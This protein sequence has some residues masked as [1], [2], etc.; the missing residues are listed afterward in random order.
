[1]M[2]LRHS[3]RI[4]RAAA[5]GGRVRLAAVPLL[6]LGC[7]AGAQSIQ[8]AQPAAPTQAY[9]DYLIGF[10]LADDGSRVEALRHLA[11]SLR[12]EPANNPAAALVFELLTEQRT[13]SRLVLRGHTGAINAVAFSPDGATLVTASGDHT[14]RLWNAAT[15]EP[16]T[17][18]LEHEDAVLSVA[19]SPDG[20]RLVT[21]C[22]DENARLWDVATGKQIGAA[23]NS[24]GNI[25]AV[26]FSPDGKLVSTGSDEGRARTWDAMTGQPVSPFVIYHEAVYSVAFNP[27]G[28]RLLTGTGDGIAD[29]LDPHT[30][31]RLKTFRRANIIFTAAFSPDGKTIL[32]SSADHT[33]ET[34]NALT[35]EPG[36]VLRHGYSVDFAAFS[37][38]ASRVVTASWDHTAR[39]WDARTGEPLTAPL[40]HS[41]TVLRA[42]ISRDNRLAVTASQ[43]NTARLWDTASGEQLRLPVRVGSG[44]TVVLFNRAGT[45]VV[46]GAGDSSVQVFDMP[47]AEPAPAW[48]ADLADF[49][50]TQNKYN[51]TRQPDLDKIRALRTRLLASTSDAPWARFGR[52]YFAESAVRPISPWSTVPL[53]RFVD[54]LIQRGDRASLEYARSLS[55]DQPTWMVRIVPLLAR[56]PPESSAKADPSS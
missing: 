38:D 56:L 5:K 47:P 23:M 22:A 33:A 15:G 41:E 9:V 53:K 19:F 30:G 48:L 34:W 31:A 3:A 20:T 42:A 45:S 25:I 14:A 26:A 7:A 51:Q 36:P 37:P 40:Q 16:L 10:K 50:A 49:A 18:P 4:L 28:S 43:D 46:V 13:S 35:G 17:P 52:W 32:T 24:T 11:E 6:L 12:L 39:V 29:L 44:A 2:Q 54:I 55:Y 27:D 21:G 8:S 1:M